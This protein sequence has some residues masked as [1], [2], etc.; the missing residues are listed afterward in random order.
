MILFQ[1]L[2]RV[3]FDMIL[4]KKK[5]L[6]EMRKKYPKKKKTILKAGMEC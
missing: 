3:S 6:Y 2:E 1:A 4:E 5:K